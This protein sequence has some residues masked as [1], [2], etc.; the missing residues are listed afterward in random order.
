M[1]LATLK[2]ALLWC[3]AIN[4][5]VLILWFILVTLAHDAFYRISARFFRIT[6]QTFDAVNYGGI[7]AYKL[8][9]LSF[10]LVPY[11]ALVLA[12]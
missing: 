3:A 12:T 4:Y 2:I 5:S 11:V 1:S 8:V 9:I 7:A 6:P 10:N